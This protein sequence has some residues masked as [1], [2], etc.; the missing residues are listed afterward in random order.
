ML[1]NE[2]ELRNHIA[3][4]LRTG[5]HNAQT[6]VRLVGGFRV[7]ILAENEGVVRAIEVKVEPRGINDDIIKCLRLIRLPEVT[8]T[9]VAAPELVISQDQIAFASKL[10]VGVI[11][12]TAS[13]LKW[14]V[15]SSKVQEASLQGGASHPSSVVPG[16]VFELEIHTENGGG[17]IARNLAARCILGGPFVSAPGT[18][19]GMYK[20]SSL[21][22]GDKWSVRFPIKVKTNATSGLYPVFTTIEAQGLQPKQS[23][24][25]IKVDTS[26]S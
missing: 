5:G 17:K 16:Q 3:D 20:R 25:N 22:P 18:K 10:G 19:K 21:D 4:L 2:A 11:L 12:A 23:V 8:E 15:T 9:Y 7:D 14:V 6:E 26:R 13:E 1:N 24:F